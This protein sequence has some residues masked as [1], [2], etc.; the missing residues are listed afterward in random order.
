MEGKE[1]SIPLMEIHIN[2]HHINGESSIRI[3][4][5]NDLMLISIRITTK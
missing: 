2:N 1:N 4:L 5:K 3:V